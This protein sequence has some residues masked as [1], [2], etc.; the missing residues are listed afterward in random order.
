[1]NHYNTLNLP[2]PNQASKPTSSSDIK[3]AY[4][5]ALLKHHPDKSPPQLPSKNAQRDVQTL[6]SPPPPSIDT[7]KTAFRVLSDPTLRAQHD[8]HLLLQRDPAST[9]AAAG[10]ARF[11]TGEE[12]VD[13]DDLRRDEQKGCWYRAC[14][15]GEQRGFVVSEEQLEAEEARGGREVVVGCCGCSLWLRVGFGVVDDDGFVQGNAGGAG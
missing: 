14:R 10:A 2:S 4:R 1:M 13:L 11:H 12:V 8:Q 9:P 5:L 3:Q 7:I 6:S 15:C